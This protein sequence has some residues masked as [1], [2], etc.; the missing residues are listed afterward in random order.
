MADETVDRSCAGTGRGIRIAVIDSGVH[1]AHPHVQGIA[2]GVAIAP[3]GREHHDYVDRLGHG[4]AVIA[5]IKEKAP[6]AELFAVKVFD[7]VLATEV[8]ALIRAIEWAARSGIRLVNLSLGTTHP[9]HEDVLRE[10]VERAGKAGVLIVAAR[11]D[12][13]IRWLPGS[14]AGVVPVQVDWVCPRDRY[15][16]VT[17][18]HGEVL[19]RA[20]GFPREIPGVPPALNL[21]GASFAVANMTGFVA[22]ALEVRPAASFEEL[23]GL[24]RD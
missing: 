21:K 12:A 4:T 7:R 8:I 6:E 15:R 11:D 1:A 24:L 13:G 10:A 23:M 2:G 19:F 9:E 5:A 20:S 18:S 17:G 3:D 22:R 16:V 14:L